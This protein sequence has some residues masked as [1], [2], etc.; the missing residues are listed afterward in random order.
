MQTATTTAADI[1][2]TN[3]LINNAIR[4]IKSDIVS[5]RETLRLHAKDYVVVAKNRMHVV[6][7]DGEM[8]KI[9][10]YPKLPTV[11]YAGDVAYRIAANF[12]AHTGD[13]KKIELEVVRAG[14][15]AQAAINDLNQRC[16]DLYELLSK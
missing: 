10:A 6:Q 2:N 4:N 5:L 3:D 15:F 14:Q 16:I 7:R 9:A 8:A 1:T 13:G 11:F 12:K